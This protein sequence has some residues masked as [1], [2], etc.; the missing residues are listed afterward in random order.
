MPRSRSTV[1][2]TAKKS[3]GWWGD[4]DG[5]ISDAYATG[6]VTAGS[7]QPICRRAGG[8]LERRHD[9]QRLCHRCGHGRQRQPI[10]RRAGGVSE[11]RHAQRRLCHR[12]R[13]A[14]A[15]AARMSAGWWGTTYGTISDAYATGAVSGDDEC[16]RAGGQ[17]LWL[18]GTITNGTWDTQTSGTTTGIGL[19]NAQPD[20]H[21]PDDGATAGRFLGRAGSAARLR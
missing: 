21:R 11:Q 7:R 12:A 8:V 9:H 4:S 15:A 13:S 14:A 20:R 16:R 19:D 5:T 6:M 3:A 1:A 10:C 17:E 2:T 18:D